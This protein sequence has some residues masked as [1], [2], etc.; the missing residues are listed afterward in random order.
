MLFGVL[1]ALCLSSSNAADFRCDFRYYTDIETSQHFDY[2]CINIKDLPVYDPTITKVI[3]VHKYRDKLNI[4]L[5][6]NADVVSV[7]I[8]SKTISQIPKGLITAFP[9]LSKLLITSKLRHLCQS[10]FAD[11]KQ[12]QKLEISV[13]YLTANIFD[14]LINLKELKLENSELAFL[15]N[16]VFQKL[17]DLEFVKI[18]GGSTRK[19][20]ELPANLFQNNLKLRQ[21]VFNTNGLSCIRDGLLNGLLKLED[22]SFYNDCIKAEYPF[23][24]LSAIND[25]I[26][27]NCQSSCINTVIATTPQTPSNVIVSGT[28]QQTP[29]NI[30]VSGTTPQTPSNVIV[31]GTTPQTPSNVVV[32]GNTPQNPKVA[33][34][35]ITGNTLPTPVNFNKTEGILWHPKVAIEVII[36]KEA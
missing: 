20:N 24:T 5:F 10:D 19:M 27:T 21:I 3:G 8:Y 33:I 13:D 9:K 18:G 26:R 6:T 14:D 32:P 23:F 17:P 7:E 2:T 30:T 22:V 15:P 34:E 12:L 28:T 35:V 4:V 25:K 11:L 1:G 16:M 31:S 36:N 29:V